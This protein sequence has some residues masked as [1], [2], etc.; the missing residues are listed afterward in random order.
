[1]PLLRTPPRLTRTHQYKVSR[2]QC[3]ADKKA[4]KKKKKC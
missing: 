3:G 2:A 4:I 1:M